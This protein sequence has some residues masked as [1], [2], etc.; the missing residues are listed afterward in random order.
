MSANALGIC[1]NAPSDRLCE[2]STRDGSNPIY[3]LPS[4]PLS[5]GTLIGQIDGPRA[6]SCDKP[7]YRD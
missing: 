2:V 4:D 7:A 1:L 6:I 5:V 3:R